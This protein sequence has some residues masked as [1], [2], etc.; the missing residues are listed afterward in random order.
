VFT[1]GF[2]QMR[3]L[4]CHARYPRR[5]WGA[6]RSYRGGMLREPATPCL[7]ALAAVVLLVIVTSSDGI[8]LQLAASPWR[9]AARRTARRT[10][11]P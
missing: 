2:F 4:S 7:I 6:V 5:P 8:D 1:K 11:G 9:S 10:S 3:H